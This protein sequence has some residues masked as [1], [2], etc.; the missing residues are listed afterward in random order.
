MAGSLGRPHLPLLKWIKDPVV[1]VEPQEAQAYTE[2]HKDIDFVVLPESGRGF[3]YM[4]NQMVKEA[5]RRGEDY[6]VFTDDDVFGLKRRGAVADKFSRVSHEDARQT[7]QDAVSFARDKG[8][9]QLAVSFSG[10]SWAAKKAL[11]G[12]TGAWGVYI[13]NTNAVRAVGGFDENLWIFADWELSARLIKSG[14]ACWRT[15]LITFEH[16]MRGMDGGAQWLY[17]NKEKVQQACIRVASQY[18]NAVKIK[19]VEAHGMHEIRFNWKA[20]TA[21]R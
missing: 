7:L 18:G 1:L 3:S 5:A 2:K 4:M 20:L 21:E 16:K 12:P 10:Q 15:N 14:Y 6:F 13:C 11:V 19:W 17:A 9:A 8:L